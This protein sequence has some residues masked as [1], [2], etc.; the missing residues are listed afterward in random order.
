MALLP[1]P[2][3]WL[4]P[5]PLLWTLLRLRLLLLPRLV[6]RPNQLRGYWRL[7]SG[8]H[9]RPFRVGVLPGSATASP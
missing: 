4:L 8:Q 9:T 3:Q 6:H 1:V 5:L 7:L 2:P